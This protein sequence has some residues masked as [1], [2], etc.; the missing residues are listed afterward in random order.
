MADE[1]WDRV[2]SVAHDCAV[3]TPNASGSW[4][5]PA[6][7]A[8]P[9]ALATTITVHRILSSWAPTTRISFLKLQSSR[10]SLRIAG[11]LT[12]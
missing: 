7:S 5:Q 11:R 12:K 3:T 1:A 2:G 4:H 8:N 6:G 9:T 10:G